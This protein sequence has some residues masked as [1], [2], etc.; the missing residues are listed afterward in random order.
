M[1]VGGWITMLLSVGFVTSLFGW[2][3]YRVLRG[4]AEPEQLARVEPV[5]EDEVDDR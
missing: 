4:H 3:I 1:T 5:G 2:C